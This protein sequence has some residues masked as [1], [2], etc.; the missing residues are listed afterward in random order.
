MQ[1]TLVPQWNHFRNIGE[2][3]T[4]TTENTLYVLQ[5]FSITIIIFNYYFF[6]L[7]R[8][9]WSFPLGIVLIRNSNTQ[10][11]TIVSHSLSLSFH[12]FSI[13]Q[14]MFETTFELSKDIQ[15]FNFTAINWIWLSMDIVLVK[16]FGMC[17]HCI[18]TGWEKCEIFWWRFRSQAGNW[19]LILWTL[20][21][22]AHRRN[23][24]REK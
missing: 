3:S 23:T 16:S 6:M 1:H 8:F 18:E 9:V 13:V 21:S 20:F 19:I 15:S 7:C 4:T 12:S 10:P 17:V 14:F 11:A 22:V 24:K 5:N 2:N